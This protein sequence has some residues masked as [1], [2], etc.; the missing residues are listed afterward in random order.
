MH[1]NRSMR[2]WSLLRYL[3]QARTRYSV[4]SPFVYDFIEKVLRNKGEA[5]WYL[6]AERTRRRMLHDHRTLSFEDFGTGGLR[7]RLYPV[8]IS[9]IARHSGRKKKEGRMLA[10][11]A[12]WKQP[13][14]IVELGT[15]LGISTLYLAAA[16]P[17]AQII[18][19]EGCRE[20]LDMA[21]NNFIN[22]GFPHIQTLYGPFETTLPQLLS[23]GLQ[24][25]LVLFDGNH[26]Y[27]P[28]ISYFRHLL[29]VVHS[30]TVFV[31]DDI[32]WSAGME[33]AWHEIA[34]HPLVTLSVD[35]F[36]MGLVFFR[37]GMEKQH[38]VLR[39]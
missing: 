2:P 8:R 39:F 26:A 31:F 20:V 4:H 35:I 28:T 11:L 34:A 36:S 1:Q 14:V 17:K 37:S 18:T 32:H 23:G 19:L 9:K 29:P 25:D 5:A 33:K 16:C 13:R 3:F 27:Q 22:A 10:R 15:S 21:R 12:A 7:Q 38:F 24:P 30:D 6:A